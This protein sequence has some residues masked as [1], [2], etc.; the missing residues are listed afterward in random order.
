ML[1]GGHMLENEEIKVL[2]IYGSWRMVITEFDF[3]D[4][5][6][7]DFGSCNNCGGCGN[8]GS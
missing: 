2:S 1:E 7:L 5:I 8:C 4:E 3:P 6:S